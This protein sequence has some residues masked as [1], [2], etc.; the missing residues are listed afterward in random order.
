MFWPW[1]IPAF[2]TSGC[3][4]LKFRD[5]SWITKKAWFNTQGRHHQGIDPRETLQ[6]TGS[7][8]KSHVY[9]KSMG[10]HCKSSPK[11]KYFSARFEL[12][13]APQPLALIHARDCWLRYP[14]DPGS[15]TW[16]QG[17][18]SN[19]SIDCC[20]LVVSSAGPTLNAS[21]LVSHLSVA[22]R[23]SNLRARTNV[24]ERLSLSHPPMGK[25]EE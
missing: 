8:R 25:I 7:I 4:W 10:K 24:L 14:F 16:R 15:G 19:S 5:P 11:L 12:S 23:S 3:V 13:Q 18:C 21:F 2:C 20:L 9:H 22:R 17:S 1:H 6:S